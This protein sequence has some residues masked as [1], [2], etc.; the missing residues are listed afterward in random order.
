MA[1]VGSGEVFRGVFVVFSWCFCAFY[2]L[3][4]FPWES[5]VFSEISWCCTTIALARPLSNL[6]LLLVGRL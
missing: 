5:I 2:R 3:G 6:V 1:R 4:T